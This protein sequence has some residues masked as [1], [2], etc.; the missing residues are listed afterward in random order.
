MKSG[1]ELI[2]EEFQ[3]YLIPYGR[4]VDG[5]IYDPSESK[6]ISF[7]MNEED[8]LMLSRSLI[9]MVMELSEL[10]GHV[11]NPITQ[12]LGFDVYLRRDAPLVTEFCEDVDSLS[13]DV[14]VL[15]N[16]WLDL[17]KQLKEEKET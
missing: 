10:R 11:T 2:T 12:L 8:C 5:C 1:F 9:D 4:F 14:E 3:L 16:A 17:A 15:G 13:K 6:V 7:R